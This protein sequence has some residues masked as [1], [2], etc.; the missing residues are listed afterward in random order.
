MNFL[1]LLLDVIRKS[2]KIKTR[3]VFLVFFSTEKFTNEDNDVIG[4]SPLFQIQYCIW[5]T[6]P[7]FFKIKKR[8]ACEGGAL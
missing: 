4:C 1:F 7:A 3:S 5:H 2:W 8:E 6:W